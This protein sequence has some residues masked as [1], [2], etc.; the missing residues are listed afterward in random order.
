MTVPIA[1]GSLD[2]ALDLVPSQMLASSELGIR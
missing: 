2:Q 1:L